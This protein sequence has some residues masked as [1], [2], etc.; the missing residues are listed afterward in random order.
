MLDGLR[1]LLKSSPF[2]ILMAVYLIANSVFNGFPPGSK[3]SSGRAASYLRRP[4]WLAGCCCWVQFWGPLFYPRF[5]TGCA[6]AN[7]TCYLAFWG[8]SMAFG[9]DLG[10]GI[11]VVVG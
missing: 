10:Q 6:S 9:S 1:S 8:L 3:A 5:P 11:L 4:A 2:W 7:L